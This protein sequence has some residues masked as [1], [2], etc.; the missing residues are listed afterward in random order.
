M[1]SIMFYLSYKWPLL[2]YIDGKFHEQYRFR[3][4][5]DL[6][7]VPAPNEAGRRFE[8]WFLD[9]NHHDEINLKRMPRRH[10]KIYGKTVPDDEKDE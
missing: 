8:G 3:A 2:V 1:F 5:E 10:F 9:P 4:G 7:V 6:S